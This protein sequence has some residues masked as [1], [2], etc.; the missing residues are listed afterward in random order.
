M[1]N[2][3]LPTSGSSGINKELWDKNKRLEHACVEFESIFIAHM[4]KTMGKTVD[5]GGLL[6]N[7]N[8]TK[9]IKSMLDENLANSIATAGGIGIGSMLFE[10]L[11]T[12]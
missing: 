3:I 8:E 9:I 10:K 2:T 5:K 6:G 4:L 1:T 11:K 12:L 7:S